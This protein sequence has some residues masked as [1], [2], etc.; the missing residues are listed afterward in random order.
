MRNRVPA[1]AERP[2]QPA[3]RW[4]MCRLLAWLLAGL[5]VSASLIGLGLEVFNRVTAQSGTFIFV[6]AAAIAIFFPMVG[7]VIALRQPQNP[8]GWLFCLIG[9]GPALSMLAIPYVI[10]TYRVNPG[11]LPAGPFM[12][13]ISYWAFVAG[14]SLVPL[15]LLLFPDGKLLSPRWRWAVWAVMLSAV[16]TIVDFAQSSWPLRGPDIVPYLQNGID[17]QS[18]GGILAQILEIIVLP[19]ALGGWLSSIIGMVLRFRRS[20]GTER[21]QMKWFAY[22]LGLTVFIQVII[23][24]LPMSDPNNFYTI[25]LIALQTISII[26]VALAIGIA[27]L[28]YRLYDIDVVINRTLVYAVL[29]FILAVIYVGL[30]ILLQRIFT[31]FIEGSEI[32]IV[33]STLVTAALFTPLHHRVQNS[34]DRR[35][36]RRKYDTRQTLETF[37]ATV[38]NEIALEELTD[39]LLVTV[40][41]TMQPTHVSLWLRAKDR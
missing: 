1:T 33:G 28:R 40:E 8:I 16:L 18:D 3:K 38:R 26:G 23:L 4:Q 21:Q 17:I 2:M 20:Q 14:A 19:L 11:V 5:A 41:E 7:L 39:H 13:W 6:N 24:R 25:A 35:F 30:V 37:N 34:I 32:A 9:L 15:L 12:S 27:I 31:P 36:Y 29:T 22:A 10:Y